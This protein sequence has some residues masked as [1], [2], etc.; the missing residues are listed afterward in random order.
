MLLA[1]K[2]FDWIDHKIIDGVFDGTARLFGFTGKKARVLQTGYLQSYALVIFTAV[3][4]FV[5]AMSAPL[6][7][8]AFK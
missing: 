2:V 7:G 1:G 4:I 3:V 8:G 5:L 6:I